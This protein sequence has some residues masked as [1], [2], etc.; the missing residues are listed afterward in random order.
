MSNEIFKTSFDLDN[1]IK[2]FEMNDYIEK[3]KR[4]IELKK[5]SPDDDDYDADDLLYTNAITDDILGDK[6]DKSRYKQDKITY[7][8]VQSTIRTNNYFTFIDESLLST[9]NTYVYTFTFYPFKSLYIDSYN[10]LIYFRLKSNFTGSTLQNINTGKDIFYINLDIGKR[11]TIDALKT[12]IQSR[13]ND[14]IYSN[15]S[16]EDLQYATDPKNMFI[17]DVELNEDENDPNIV[18]ITIDIDPNY[19]YIC[20]FSE[21]GQLN[22]I[23][24]YNNNNY[25]I[26]LDS[27]LENVK[28]IRLISSNIKNSDTIINETNNL[29]K[30]SI[31][32]AD[33]SYNI[34]N[35]WHYVIQCGDYTIDLLLTK[36]ITELNNIITLNYPTIIDY[37]KYTYDMITG[38]IEITSK[39]TYTN[40]FIIDFVYNINLQWRNLLVMLG[41]KENITVYSNKITNGI[42]KNRKPSSRINNSNIELHGGKTGNILYKVP[43]MVPVLEKTKNIWIDV[44]SYQTLLDLNTDIW[45]FNKFSFFKGCEEQDGQPQNIVQIFENP[46]YLDRLNISLYDDVGFPY[47]TNSEDHWFIFEIIYETDRLYSTN[48]SSKRDTYGGLHT[49]RPTF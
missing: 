5:I 1:E 30:F 20:Q 47:N 43:Y 14:V 23:N 19:T 15:I 10:A 7:L 25:T 6:L 13:I 21:E 39:S 44:N 38:I 4:A 42:L 3:G 41:F 37:F 27:P 24:D 35:N 31:T 36:I 2:R 8:N 45:Y 46:I 48:I 11:Y 17:V 12:D 32:N 16:D 34:N 33:G 22:P 40:M 26:M 9:G 18:S 28:S 49:T 29:I